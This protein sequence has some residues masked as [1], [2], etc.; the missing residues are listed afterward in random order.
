MTAAAAAGL[1]LAAGEGR[2]F[3]GPKAVVRVGGER[4]VDRAVRLLADGG[5][6]PVLVVDGA[7]RLTVR[8]ARVVHNPDWGTG[9]G[10]SLR[11]G[12]RALRDEPA[13]AVVVVLVDQPWL[14]PGA[15]HRLRAARAGGA[16]VAV[17]TYGGDRKS[18]V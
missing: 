10:S 13:G 9:M 8:R 2:R 7:V 5:C 18:V 12:L 11:A 3:G 17:A 6:V 14:G 15:V 4:L 16:F 1:V